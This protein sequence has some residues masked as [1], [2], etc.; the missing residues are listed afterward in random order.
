MST[1]RAWIVRLAGLFGKESREQEF[2]AEVESHLQMHI[3]ENLRRGLTPQEAR[4]QALI[5]LGGVEKTREEMRELRSA[6]W[7]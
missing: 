7:L 4:R 1:F 5:K 2:S 6:V 3:E